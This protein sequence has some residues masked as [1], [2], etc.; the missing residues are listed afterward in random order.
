[1]SIIE[2]INRYQPTNDEEKMDKE[3][4][5]NWITGSKNL[6]SRENYQAHFTASS[7]I[8]N[9][10]RTKVLM[11]YH[12]IFH[13]WS[14]TGGHA[15]LDEDLRHVALIEAIEETSIKN[16]R[17]LSPSIFSLEVLTVDGH[18]K[19]GK[20]VSS[21]LHMNVTYLFEAD[22]TDDIKPLLNENSGVKWINRTDI[23][24]VCTEV[25]MVEH[26]YNKL[27]EKLK[28]FIISENRPIK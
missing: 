25:W 9:K 6:F 5:C 28:K 21:H 16:I 2:D 1:M 3:S 19:M 17:L 13:A 18:Y 22:E 4:I 15:D 14:W 20:Y 7:W 26:I 11:V 10:S 8:V 12:N 24:N 23:Q 27:E